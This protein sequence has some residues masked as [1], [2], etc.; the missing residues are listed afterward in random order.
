MPGTR[1]GALSS[2]MHLKKLIRFALRDAT[3]VYT[4]VADTCTMRPAVVQSCVTVAR[5]RAT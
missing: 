5:I 4:R 1:E 3:S 2:S